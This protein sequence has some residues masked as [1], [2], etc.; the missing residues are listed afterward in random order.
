MNISKRDVVKNIVSL[1]AATGG[2][3]VV[4]KMMKNQYE[5]NDSTVGSVVEL[6]GYL[7]LM[8]AGGAV[9]SKGANT[10]TEAVYGL[11]DKD[12]P[13]VVEEDETDEEEE[14]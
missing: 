6:I 10:V 12:E 2:G 1:V 3:I 8:I 7:G 5:Q 14:A 9:A 11:I 13:E 4:G